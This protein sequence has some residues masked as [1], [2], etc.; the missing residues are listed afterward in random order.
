MKKALQKIAEK[1]RESFQ[2]I[3][4]QIYLIINT[5]NSE[6][7]AVLYKSFLKTHEKNEALVQ[8]FESTYSNRVE[9][10]AMHCRMNIGHGN[11]N[12][13]ANAE[14]FHNKLKTKYIYGKDS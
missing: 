9:K 8:Y 1:A 10:W 13:T 5:T 12:T 7:F 4:D 14:S 11:I 3:F 2:E 6:E